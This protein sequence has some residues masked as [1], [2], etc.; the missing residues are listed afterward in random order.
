MLP[1]QLRANPAFKMHNMTPVMQ[2]H[3]H[4]VF[5]VLFA[6]VKLFL[7][8]AQLLY[9]LFTV[10]RP[11]FYLVNFPPPPPRLPYFFIPNLIRFPFSGAKSS[12]TSCTNLMPSR[13]EYM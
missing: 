8:A 6:A 5:F 9:R 1:E 10:S 11:S 2:R 13:I 4:R 7:Q 3:W 12:V